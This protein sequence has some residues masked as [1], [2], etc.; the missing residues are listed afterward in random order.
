MI[1]RP[2]ASRQ[3]CLRLSIAEMHNH[4]R[5]LTILTIKRRAHLL[6]LVPTGLLGLSRTSEFLPTVLPLLP[7]LS[8]G[9]LDLGCRS[10]SHLSVVGFELLHRLG[11]VVDESEAS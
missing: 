7:L 2:N 9:L 6:L 10:N 3:L 1:L 5:H 4:V 11:R 8:A